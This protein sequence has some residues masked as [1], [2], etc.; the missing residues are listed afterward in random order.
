[1]WAVVAKKQLRIRKFLRFREFADE[2]LFA[3]KLL[4]VFYCLVADQSG[5][6]SSDGN[7]IAFVHRI[8]LPIHRI[9]FSLQSIDPI[10]FVH[11]M[12]E[13]SIVRATTNS[14]IFLI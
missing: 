6:Y 7:S 9:L 1:M 8:L 10:F 5:L 3:K 13:I 14:E 11:S 12:V 2:K 4:P